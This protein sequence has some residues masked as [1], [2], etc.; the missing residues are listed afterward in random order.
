MNINKENTNDIRFNC[1]LQKCPSSCC[2]VFNGI[3]SN[4]IS[5]EKRPFTEIILTCEDVEC[6]VKEGFEYYIESYFNKNFIIYKMKTFEDGTCHAFKDGF[7]NIQKCKPT[8]CNAYPFYIDQISG[9]CC[10]DCPGV[11]TDSSS[12]NDQK[13]NIKSIYSAIKMQE[14]W[15]NYYKKLYNLL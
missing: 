4:L 10:I 15:I 8:I 14:F 7:C 5:F 6:I 11:A 3:S 2:S 13:Q 12:L 1:L 9:L